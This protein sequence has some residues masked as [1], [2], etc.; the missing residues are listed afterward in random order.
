MKRPDNQPAKNIAAYMPLFLILIF[1]AAL[2]SNTFDNE[3]TYWDDNRY[4]T[5]NPRIKDLSISGVIDIFDP[6]DIT[7][8]SSLALPEYLPLTTLVHAVAY[9]IGG[10]NPAPYHAANLLL[11]LL[12]IV[13]LYYFLNLLTGSYLT[14]LLSTLIFSVLTVHV[15]SVTWVAATK[16]T[17]SFAFLMG[18]FIL[19]IKYVRADGRKAFFYAAS[20][21][22]FFIGLL[23]KSLIVTMPALLIFYDLCFEKK[24][25][26]ILDKI[27][28][29]IIGGLMMYL[30]LHV[31][32][33]FTETEYMTGTIG[34][35]RLA[36]LNLT[37]FTEYL[38]SFF[39]PVRLNAFYTYTLE[40]V[41]A[42]LLSPKVIFSFVI[43]AGSIGAG[44][45][46]F[47]KNIRLVTFSIF[48]FF[49]AFAPVINIIPSSTVR[50]DRY[51]FI[52][53]VGL[54]LLVAWAA[55]RLY[56][57]N[58]V[59]KKAVPAVLAVWVIFLSVL[60]YE[61][62]G[63]WQD[64]IT[65]WQDSLKKHPE[66]SRP[67][68]IMGNEYFHRGMT[69]DA[70]REYK[71]TLLLDPDHQMACS[72]MGAIY[73]MTGR[74]YEAAALFGRCLEINPDDT[75]MRLNMARVYIGLSEMKEAEKE[76][77]KALKSEPD[78]PEALALLDSL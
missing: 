74:L 21:T 26:K 49:I 11:Y 5:D 61:R 68:F 50:A 71:E 47:F 8:D 25:F 54:S 6:R 59:F 70:I 64:G 40:V 2:Y 35:Y 29:F 56:G 76:I 28:Y 22:L 44:I 53:S 16:D 60:T 31:N 43:V 58:P 20:V 13:L 63:V 27:P 38:G 15:E 73:A 7:Q 3:L 9:S 1:T 32:K 46:A 77:R 48:W 52:P 14:S 33:E 17:L 10:L 19:Y 36:L 72:N 65:I 69:G 41:P 67:H 42:T 30:Y 23:A 57:L 66:A 51:L 62:N 78:N 18:S 39:A 4:V 37:V 55:A 75:A 45:Y 12:N 34:W 24:R